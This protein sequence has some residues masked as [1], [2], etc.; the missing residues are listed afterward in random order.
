[1]SKDLNLDKID[2]EHK[3]LIEEFSMYPLTQNINEQLLLIAIQN[4]YPKTIIREKE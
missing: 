2:R 4:I 1:M 3:R